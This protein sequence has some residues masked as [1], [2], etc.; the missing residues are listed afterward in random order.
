MPSVNRTN[1]FGDEA[2]LAFI[3]VEINDELKRIT[4]YFRCKRHSVLQELQDKMKMYIN[5][6]ISM[7]EEQGK[8][9]LQLSSEMVGEEQANRKFVVGSYLHPS[10]LFDSCFFE[11]SQ[12]T[13]GMCLITW[14]R[15]SAN[16]TFPIIWFLNTLREQ[17]DA[18]ANYKSL[19]KS[20]ESIVTNNPTKV[21]F[22]ESL[23]EDGKGYFKRNRNI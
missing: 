3:G 7:T 4:V 21:R 20:I 8:E 13:E 17:I 11:F 6:G 5:R 1:E 12:R 14:K 18:F 10:L 9:L 15:T 23:G 2:K 16:A 22:I 19:V